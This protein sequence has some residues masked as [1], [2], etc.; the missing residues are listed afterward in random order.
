[1]FIQ[2]GEEWN[3]VQDIVALT[4]KAIC[5]VLRV[6][7]DCTKE[8]ESVLPKK[9]NKQDL[10]QLLDKKANLHDVKTTMQEIATNIESRVGLDEHRRSLD[11]KASKADLAMRLQEKVSFEDMKRYV[12]LNGGKE[13]FSDE[14]RNPSER[15]LDLI[16]DEMR[17]L[18]QRVEET[19]H[20]MQS[21]K[22]IGGGPSSSRDLTAFQKEVNQ[23]LT[24]LD[25]KLSDKAN[26]QS[27]AQALH[28]KA[29]KPELDAILAKKVD[30][31][32]LQRI[33]DAKV[34]VASF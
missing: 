34:D 7:H 8:M 32:D 19:F 20:E 13:Q 30:F 12:A 25:E 26:K 5:H 24:D 9:A 1:M 29:N 33:L 21:M 6:Q 15:N 28:R 2:A 3:G 31:E 16:D 17:R 10:A 14:K 27:V 4:F 23:K 18:K 11:E 22:Q